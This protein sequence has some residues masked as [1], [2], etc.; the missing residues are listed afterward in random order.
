MTSVDN[1]GVDMRT[2]VK[3]TR[4]LTFGEKSTDNSATLRRASLNV[5]TVSGGKP[6]AATLWPEKATQ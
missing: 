2:A 3:T 1:E 6:Q 5:A 4:T